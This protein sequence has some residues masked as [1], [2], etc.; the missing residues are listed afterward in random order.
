MTCAG[1]GSDWPLSGRPSQ[2]ILIETQ[3]GPHLFLANGSR[4]YGVS[5]SFAE[6]FRA[7]ENHRDGDG[8]DALLAAYG[9]DAPDYVD[10]D[11]PAPFAHRAISLAVAQ[12]CNLGC[13]YCYAQGGSFGGPPKSMS[14]E[15]AQQAVDNLLAGVTAGDRVNIAFLGGEPL[16]NRAVVEATTDYAARQAAQAGVSVGFSITT[17]G[18]LLRAPDA[19]FFEQH[20]FAVTISL[21]GIGAVHDAQRP[22]LGGRGSYQKILANV[23]PLLAR[24]H[25]MQV[26]A[27]VTVTPRNLDLVATLDHF[28]ELGFHSVGF[29]PMLSAPS[30]QDEMDGAHLDE[31][32][33]QMIA[34]GREFETAVNAGRRYPFMN[35]VN[36]LKEIHKGTHRP[37]P[38]GAGGGYFGVSSDGGYFGCHR[39]V[40]ET[41]G[42]FGSLED[43]GP[44]EALR[45]DWLQRRHVHF[46][47][48]CSGC[49]AR[50]LCGGGC[51]HEVD[52]RGRPSC[53]YIR[54]WLT[55]A[56]EAY[57]RLLRDAPEFFGGAQLDQAVSTAVAAAE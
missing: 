30:G 34:C 24:Q 21:D 53:D 35:M 3:D 36:A 10:N 14:I 15:V 22:Y 38:C 47:S 50:Y 55:Y 6:A 41:D 33:R 31:M 25:K 44:D 12:K 26:S 5:A 8:I 54:G 2:G 19:A 29:S 45:A 56:L 11:S 49:W 4:F 51:Y 32:L 17:N 48:P 13:T 20:G 43:G 18:T 39:F 40:D 52:R 16:V 57:V 42:Q 27:R 23:A 7:L 46:Q 1:A 9:L 28:I 37:Y